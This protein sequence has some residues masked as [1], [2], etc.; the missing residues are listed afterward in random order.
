MDFL[1]STIEDFRTNIL[2]WKSGKLDELS[3]C[4]H[5][6]FPAGRYAIGERAAASFPGHLEA[7]LPP[8]FIVQT[9]VLSSYF[10]SISLLCALTSSCSAFL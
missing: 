5:L 8:P 2:R 4:V 1:F 10:P 9:Q 3:L 7:L 6:L